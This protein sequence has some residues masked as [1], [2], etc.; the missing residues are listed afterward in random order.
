M[1]RFEGI[2][3]YDTAESIQTARECAIIFSDDEL[4][5]S[6]C[7]DIEETLNRYEFSKKEKVEIEVRY[8]KNVAEIIVSVHCP[9]RRLVGK[10]DEQILRGLKNYRS[11]FEDYYNNIKPY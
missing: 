1:L 7:K 2:K 10:S 3:E 4:P 5:K 11:R 8:I 6:I 9:L